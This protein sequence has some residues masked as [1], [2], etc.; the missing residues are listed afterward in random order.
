MIFAVTF[1]GFMLFFGWVGWALTGMGLW[2]AAAPGFFWAALAEG[3]TGTFYALA[4]LTDYNPGRLFKRPDGR[5]V[6]WPRLLTWPYLFFEYRTWKRYR[7]R[8][9]EPLFEEVA[10]GLWLG[11]RIRE[12]DLPALREAGIDAVVDLVAEFE[13]P[14]AIAR[15]PAVSYLCVPTL[16]GTP[17]SASEL[18]A[19]AR[20]VEQSVRDGRTVLVH[21]T[22]GHGRS[23]TVMAAALI[24][25][26]DAADPPAAIAMLEKCRRRIWL[27]REQKRRLGRFD[28]SRRAEKED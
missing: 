12:D 25:R 9:R 19:A 27:T 20:F 2:A 6:F 17:M 15:D 16:D 1:F 28:R 18:A 22:F 8:T 13:A 3:C 7:A 21:C 4:S 5:T 11:G 26:G 24:L 10:P 14:A 23:A